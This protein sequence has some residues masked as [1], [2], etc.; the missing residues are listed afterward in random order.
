MDVV[1]TL[2]AQHRMLGEIV[3]RLGGH[4]AHGDAVRVRVTLEELRRA[5][6]AHLELE[7]ARFYPLLQDSPL[8]DTAQLR[9]LAQSL[10]ALAERYGTG[11]FDAERFAA[12]FNA[13]TRG[14]LARLDSEEAVL[15]PLYDRLVGK[16]GLFRRV[17]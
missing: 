10:D 2:K 8:A 3:E 12:D 15:F 5:L 6:R 11:D 16:S 1:S 4:L 14:L 17:A 7:E 13:V 9:P